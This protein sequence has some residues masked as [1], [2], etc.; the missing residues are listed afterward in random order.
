MCP[1]EHITEVMVW[2]DTHHNIEWIRGIQFVAN[3]GRVSRRYGGAEGKPTVLK[4]NNGVLAGLVSMTRQD[5]E[6]K[7]DKISKL[8][9]GTLIAC[10]QRICSTASIGDLAA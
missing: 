7:V 5:P 4:N 6:W 10:N 1:G 2:S 9:V 3:T 8:Q